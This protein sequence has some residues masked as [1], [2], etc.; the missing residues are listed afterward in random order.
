MTD[1][2]DS[3]KIPTERESSKTP[4]PLAAA[5]TPLATITENKNESTDT[6]VDMRTATSSS[7]VSGNVSTPAPDKV[8]LPRTI[9]G[10]IARWLPNI[11][12]RD[13]RPSESGVSTPVFPMSPELECENPFQ[14][15]S[16]PEYAP[17]A[18]PPTRRDSFANSSF[19]LA[20]VRSEDGSVA[21]SALSD[22]TGAHFREL[23]ERLRLFLLD[24]ESQLRNIPAEQISTKPLTTEE[25]FALPFSFECA[26]GWSGDPRELE[27]TPKNKDAFLSKLDDAKNGC[28]FIHRTL[29][30]YQTEINSRKNHKFGLDFLKKQNEAI[31]I[32]RHQ[33]DQIEERIDEVV[34]EVHAISDNDEGQL[35]KDE[36]TIAYQHVYP[37]VMRTKRVVYDN[38]VWYKLNYVM[39]AHTK[40]AKLEVSQSR[41]ASTSAN[42]PQNKNGKP[43]PKIAP[44]GNGGQASSLPVSISIHI[45][46]PC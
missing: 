7:Q 12:A 8:T 35:L 26:F 4:V 6:Q 1:K 5:N 20:Q 27:N 38:H 44:V 46:M 16:S 31:V 24:N 30:E 13:A 42:R 25:K 39:G 9:P 21:C 18:G 45:S 2:N 40:P 17:L 33:L 34:N 36:L 3:F 41:P 32:T 14:M 23:D 28:T 43:I 37:W 15:A 29:T 10:N 19:S 22:A 11:S